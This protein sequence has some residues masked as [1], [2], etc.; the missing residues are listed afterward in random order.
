MEQ[1]TNIKFCFKLGKT[2]A[3]TVEMMRQVNGDNCLSRARFKSGVETIEDEARPGRPL[4]IRNEGLIAKV[5]ERIQE[6]CCATVRIM[7][8]EFGVNKETI[9]QIVVED[10][11][12]SVSCRRD[13]LLPYAR[14][15]FYR[16]LAPLQLYRKRSDL[17]KRFI[18]V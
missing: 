10:L 11:C 7:A 17:K 12:M 8:D 15:L 4:S 5:R 6:E 3:E 1:R 16:V 2:A 14:K 13:E 18:L 9:R